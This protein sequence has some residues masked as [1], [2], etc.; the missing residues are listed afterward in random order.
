MVF[1][2]NDRQWSYHDN[3]CD[4]DTS[5]DVADVSIY[6]DKDKTLIVLTLMMIVFGHIQLVTQ[7]SIT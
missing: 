3:E 1:N 6:N 7:Q 2:M 5:D 4:N